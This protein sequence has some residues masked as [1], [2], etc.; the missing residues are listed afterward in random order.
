MYF[1]FYMPHIE[2]ISTI[3]ISISIDEYQITSI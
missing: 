1:Y 2:Y 3:H